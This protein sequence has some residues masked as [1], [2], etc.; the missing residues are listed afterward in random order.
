MAARAARPSS[1]VPR[2]SLGAPAAASCAKGAEENTPFPGS[3]CLPQ[4]FPSLSSDSTSQ[5]RIHLIFYLEHLCFCLLV[6]H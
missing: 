2:L 3:S 4:C 1:R 6:Q 5:L